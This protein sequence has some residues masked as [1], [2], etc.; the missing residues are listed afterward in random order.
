M[1]FGVLFL[2]FM[3]AMSPALSQ[4][5]A[6]TNEAVIKMVKAGLSD[7]VILGVVTQQPG[8]Y[9]TG[10]DDLIMLKQAGVSD[11]VVSA[12]AAKG[13]GVRATEEIKLELGVYAKKDG[14]WI[15]L[16]PEVV[17]LKQASGFRIYTGGIDTNGHMTGLSSKTTL[18]IPIDIMIVAPEG[19][20]A[21]EYQCVR[22][23]QSAKNNSREFRVSR[24]GFGGGKTGV[25]RDRVA[26]DFKKLGPR[27]FAVSLPSSVVAGEYA[28][29]P[30]GAASG[31]LA[32]PGKAFTFRVLE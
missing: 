29:L 5:E 4:Q 15:I 28:F 2:L 22:L 11:K 16:E 19:V 26:F 1:S 13:A 25:D 27:Q 30:P 20:S 9:S 21:S 17:N 7:E 12:M 10:V 14:A 3:G 32:T 6:L 23:R 18:R 31:P 8:K 24:A